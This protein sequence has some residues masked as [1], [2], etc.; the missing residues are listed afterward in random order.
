MIT[1]KVS[2]SVH[3]CARKEEVVTRVIKFYNLLFHVAVYVNKVNIYHINLAEY[4]AL[5]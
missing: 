1:E 2:S 4:V 3:S 5:L